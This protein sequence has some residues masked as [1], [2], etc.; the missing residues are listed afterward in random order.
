VARILTMD[1]DRLAETEIAPRALAALRASKVEE[2]VVTGRSAPVDAAFTLPELVGLA[3]APGVDLR[4]D[5]SDEEIET[6]PKLALIRSL[7]RP[8]GRRR[9]TLRFNLTPTA[10]LGPERVTA[11][12]FDGERIDAGLLL[13][14]IGY[15]ALPVPGLPFDS[16]SRT[17][18]NH[19]G[20][21]IDPGTGSAV[22]RTYVTGWIKRGP[23][24]FL[25][26]NRSDSKETVRSLVEDLNAGRL[27]GPLPSAPRQSAEPA[28][29]L[30]A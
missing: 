18:P 6:A 26:T 21:V 11:V 29:S 15:G 7:R 17:V 25:G 24:G 23:T 1:P 10:V 22:T 19:R 3:A 2:V 27:R 30:V 12:E 4:I 8:R 14:S 28:R 20:R 16:G 13:T 5:A 9:V